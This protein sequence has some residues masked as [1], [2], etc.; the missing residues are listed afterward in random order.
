MQS[1]IFALVRQL[2]EKYT[3]IIAELSQMETVAKFYLLM[4]D[5]DLEEVG[6]ETELGLL[7]YLVAFGDTTI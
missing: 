1:Q 4:A 6:Y 5:V 3:E 2:P 7:R